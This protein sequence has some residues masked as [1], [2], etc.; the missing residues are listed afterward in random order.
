MQ[1]ATNR[2][3]FCTILSF[4]LQLVGNPNFLQNVIRSRRPLWLA[5]HVVRGGAG[6]ILTMSIKSRQ[7]NE[8]RPSPCSS[9]RPRLRGKVEHP[10]PVDLS[11]IYRTALVRTPSKKTRGAFGKNAK[12]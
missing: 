2:N 8:K 1:G 10:A 6:S 12:P 3:F 9:K 11:E 5:V 4:L 7:R